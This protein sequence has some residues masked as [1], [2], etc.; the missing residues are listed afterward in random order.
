MHMAATYIGLSMQI[1]PVFQSWQALLHQAG[2]TSSRTSSTTVEPALGL[3]HQQPCGSAPGT[4][5]SSVLVQ[6]ASRQQACTVG[7]E[8]SAFAKPVHRVNIVPFQHLH[9]LFRRDVR[10]HDENSGPR[11]L[12]L[13]EVERTRTSNSKWPSLSQTKN[14]ALIAYRSGSEHSV[15]QGLEP[16]QRCT[17]S[18]LCGSDRQVDV[19][20][21]I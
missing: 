9:E 2:H 5:R 10:Y 14:W 11:S 1:L 16:A 21:L 17:A 20:F 7:R 12:R 13:Q 15:I 19:E 6:A 18:L 3:Q 8:I 4:K